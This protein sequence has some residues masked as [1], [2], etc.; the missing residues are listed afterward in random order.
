V[1]TNKINF[2]ESIER[3]GVGVGLSLQVKVKHVSHKE[4]VGTLR[5]FVGAE[6]VDVQHV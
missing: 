1:V 3:S 2:R 6:V 5:G 4:S